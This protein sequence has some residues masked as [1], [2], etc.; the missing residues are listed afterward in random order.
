MMTKSDLERL[1]V[2]RLEDAVFLLQANR[3]SAA[4]ICLATPLSSLS[5][6][7]SRSLFNQM[8]IRTRHLSTPSMCIDWIAC[9]AP[10]AFGL[11]SMQMGKQTQ[12]YR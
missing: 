9:S 4:T 1:A 2:L 5:R 6:H 3:C 8:L 12:N 10:Q 7:A 11:I